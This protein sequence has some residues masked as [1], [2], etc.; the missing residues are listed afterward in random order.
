MSD[1]AVIVAAARSPMGRAY[2]GAFADT[3]PEDLGR[4]VIEAALAQVPGLDPHTI[5]DIVLGCGQP[6]GEHGNNISRVIAVQLGLD[7]VPGMT[8]TRYCSASIQALRTAHHAIAAGEGDVFVTGGLELESRHRRGTSDYLPPE[9]QA[10]VGG[11][12]KHH[13]FDEADAAGA[14]P[15]AGRRPVG[16]PARAR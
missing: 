16:R 8:M 11:S 15:R 4:Q 9:A 7:T 13:G 6:G 5:D 1:R 2:K 14:V 3:R 10:L 12:W